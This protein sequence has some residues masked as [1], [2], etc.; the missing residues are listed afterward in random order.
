M[1]KRIIHTVFENQVELT[2]NNVAVV[3]NDR[4]L[5]YRELNEQ[6]NILANTLR[7]YG[8]VQNKIVC[9]I[10]PSGANLISSL[11]GV[12]KSAGIYLPLDL[13]LSPKRLGQAL[14]DSKAE[15]CVTEE[16]SLSS[17]I[18]LLTV[19][20]NSIKYLLVLDSA[21]NLTV[22]SKENVTGGQPCPLR[23]K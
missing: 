17:V 12:F 10:L 21:G 8:V 13:A 14:V 23:K 15:F 11:L 2:P 20:E 16:E 19:T 4:Q 18:D 7:N 3:Q 22:K 6:S 9:S 5:S 1:N